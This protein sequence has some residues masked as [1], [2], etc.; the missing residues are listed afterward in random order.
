VFAVAVL[1]LTRP[2]A[3]L[4]S[5]V[6]DGDAV[7]ATS[8]LP[9]EILPG[10]PL[11]R[12]GVDGLLGTADDVIEDSIVGD[13]DLVV[14]LGN[15]S[16]DPVIPPPSP[17]RDAIVDTVAGPPDI[18][19]PIPFSVFVSD[20]DTSETQPYGRVLPTADLEGLP[21]VV[22]LF[23]DLDGDGR[24]GPSSRKPE[25]EVRSIAELEPIG[26]DVAF[27]HQGI[28]RGSVAVTRGAPASKGGLTIVATAMAFTGSYDPNFVGGFVPTGPGITTAQPFVPDRR[29][30]RLFSDDIGP[31]DVGGTLNPKPRA[32]G[33][34]VPGGV[35]DLALRTDGS[36]PTIDVARALAG[37]AVC[38]RL[39]ERGRRKS[40]VPP[41]P[42]Q[43]V[44][45]AVARRRPARAH[46]QLLP[47]DRLGNPADPSVPLWVRV[48]AA[49]PA[50]ILPNR[51]ADPSS[52]TFQ[53]D[54]A[55]G[56]FVGFFSTSA[57]NGIFRV[58][59]GGALCQ[60]FAFESRPT[61]PRQSADAWVAMRGRTVYRS[62]SEAVAM[63]TDRNQD[64]H[65]TIEI[66]EGVF[67]ESVLL[68]RA[69][70]LKGAGLGRTVIDARGTG[71]ALRLTSPG[72][73]AQGLTLT[74][75]ISGVSMETGGTLRNLEAVA[76]VGDGFRLQS[77]GV[78]ATE[79][80]ARGNGGDGLVI[81]AT[82]VVSECVS[83]GNTGAGIAVRSATDAEVVDNRTFANGGDGIA[84]TNAV[85]P[86][87]SRNASAGNLAK[88]LSLE[89]TTGGRVTANLLA[90]ND[91]AGLKLGK[92]NGALIDSN[93]CTD[94]GGYGMRIDRSTADF[95][96]TPGDQ[97][98][99]GS[100]D[101]SGNRK[102]D[103]LFD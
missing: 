102:G 41:E 80:V 34:P 62:I 44:F 24:I 11:I 43:W 30:D 9:Y 40:A 70:E 88:G 15:L 48:S 78:L 82:S 75:G 29:L 85:H 93:D 33:L 13:I 12:P 31:L 76:N 58:T 2:A 37:K 99:P 64:G 98:A 81:A 89:D 49:G 96:A 32:A 66:G 16:L 73:G 22:L 8:G 27:L 26:R 55:R 101:V 91:D 42:N 23:A 19:V 36:N 59:V 25:I 100:N 60:E 35:L 77:P 52:E 67:R 71:T 39:M 18:G 72:A 63:A 53:L 45:N 57:G 1:A 28:A 46:L 47:V 95:D 68:D 74:G 92:S 10:Q 14:R 94:N 61:R 79:C 4:V 87:V 84:V 5:S 38:A 50:S 103:L 97:P 86:L 21:V 6:F 54:D 7:D 83:S 56:A 69:V 20:G 51:D 17:L 3:G 90:G 65:I